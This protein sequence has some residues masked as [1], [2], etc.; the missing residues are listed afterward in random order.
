LATHVNTEGRTSASTYGY[1]R[2]N[3]SNRLW[4]KYQALIHNS[5]DSFSLTGVVD[6]DSGDTVIVELTTYGESSNTVDIGGASTIT[7]GFS[8]QLIS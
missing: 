7:T 5:Q 8:G 3:T 4:V 6:M 2:F 1:F